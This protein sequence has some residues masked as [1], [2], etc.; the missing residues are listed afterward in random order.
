MLL[1]CECK[2]TDGINAMSIAKDLAPKMK[3]I[4]WNDDSREETMAI[5][6]RSFSR[7]ITSFEGIPVHCLDLDTMEHVLF[8]D[9]N[10]SYEDSA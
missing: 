8:A 1:A 7:T 6:A 5:F 3:Q 2:W 9:F 4:Q 10:T